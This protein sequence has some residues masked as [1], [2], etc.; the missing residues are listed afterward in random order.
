MSAYGLSIVT[1]I[2]I[3]VILALSLNLIT[4]LC[5]QVSLGHAAF[6]G[7]GAYAAGL[8]AL[9]HV[10]FWLTLPAGMIAAGAFGVIVGFCSLRVRDDFLAI[11]TMA[12][13]FIFVG[14]LKSNESLGGEE[15]LSGIPLPS[16]G[17]S[18][19]MLLAVMAALATVLLSFYVKRSWL[20][21]AFK[22]VAADDGAAQTIGIDD[23]SFKLMA[24]SIGTALAGLAGGL[25]AYYLRSLDPGMFGFIASVSILLM[26]V[27]G[28]MGSVLGCVIAAA[29]LTLMP[30]I[31]RF[32]ADYKL[33]IFGLLLFLVMRFMPQGLAGLPLL[34]RGRSSET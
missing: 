7:V 8:L 2:G 22:A 17:T 11:A 13:D 9:A 31:L 30:D 16:F 34:L 23:R 14:V 25:F 5:G 4:G 24:F 28:G 21:F 6:F 3:N 15:G 12:A 26:V 10:P 18:G 33:L 1:L 20:G 27:L 32:A 29:A 19:L